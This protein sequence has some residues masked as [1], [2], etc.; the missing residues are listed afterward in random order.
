MDNKNQLKDIKK[1]NLKRV[2]V[3]PKLL[4]YG[5]IAKLTHSTGTKNGDGGQNMMV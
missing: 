2:Y 5:S 3:S 4:E 1:S